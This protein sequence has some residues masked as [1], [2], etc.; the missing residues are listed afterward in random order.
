VD[1]SAKVDFQILRLLPATVEDN[2]TKEYDWCW[3]LEMEFTCDSVP[4][5]FAHPINPSI[6]VRMPG[7]PTYLLES[8]F[9]VSLASTLYEELL[10]QDRR[11][12]PVV[13]RSLFFPYRHEGKACFVCQEDE[14]TDCPGNIRYE[15][16][17]CSTCGPRVQVNRS[18]G[19]RILEH[20]GAHILFDSTIGNH[21]QELC[22]L[23]LRPSPM[24]RLN[25]KKGR[26]ATA[27]YNIDINSSSCI[28]LVR[29]NCATAARSS[30]ASPCSNVPIICPLC[31]AKSPAVWTYNLRTHFRERHK[32]P[33]AQFPLKVQ[34][35][36]SEKYGMRRIWDA[37][38]NIPKIRNL[39]NK[40]KEAL[41]LSEAHSSRAA[42]RS[43]DINIKLHLSHC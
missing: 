12:I 35:S 43:V 26:G 21:S 17:D 34:L 1:S 36:E 37:R 31:P 5:R 6:S 10:P 7:K 13:K 3:S 40:K 28:N 30:D 33:D 25:L 39:K 38:F 20:M 2:P 9:L 18:N 29:F 11:E 19:Q 22:G 32:L 16:S 27:G 4:G 42:L 41:T 24:C 23:C 15:T 14:A 8:S